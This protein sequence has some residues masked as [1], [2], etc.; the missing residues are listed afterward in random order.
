MDL[1][2]GGTE[3]ELI[4]TD[5]FHFHPLAV[6]D[7]LG[8]QHIPRVD[9]WQDYL[10]TVFS[11]L[12]V[13]P[14]SWEVDTA[15]IDVFLGP[16]YLVTHQTRPAEAVEQVWQAMSGAAG[17]VSADHLLYACRRRM[18]RLLSGHGPAG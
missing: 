16:S 4:L 7:A 15:E 18:P 11:S 9:D 12:S 6:E 1:Q 10:Y 3:A 5:I 2:S 8:Q 14:R 17:A 13:H